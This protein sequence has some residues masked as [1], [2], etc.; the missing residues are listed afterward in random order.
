MLKKNSFCF[1]LSLLI[2]TCALMPAL[3]DDFP[4]KGDRFAWSNA[5]PY[6]NLANKY[7]LSTVALKEAKNS[8][9]KLFTAMNTIPIFSSTTV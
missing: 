4:G 5:L 9:K 7:L 1:V 3:S 8:L 2:S 6:Y